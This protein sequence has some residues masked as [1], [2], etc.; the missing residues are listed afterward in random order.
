MNTQRLARATFVLERETHDQLDRVSR[1]LGVSRSELVRD[2]LA[3]PVALM[4]KW[5]DLVPA[6]P[7]PEEKR[8]LMAGMLGDINE[9]A[10][11]ELGAGK[12]AD[13]TEMAA[14]GK[15]DG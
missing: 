10:D 11:R 8:A 12:L 9:M 3:E 6:N 13:I 5:V 15:S 14:R 4:A 7:T 2:M 1:T